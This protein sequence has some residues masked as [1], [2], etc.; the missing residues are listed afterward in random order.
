MSSLQVELV[1]A[2]R[3]VWSGEATFVI[4]RTAEG[5]LGA[6]PGHSPVLSNLKPSVVEISTTD[7]ERVKAAV[8]DGFLSIANDRVSILS[9]EAELAGEIDTEAAKAEREAAEPDSLAWL[10]ADAKV[11]ATE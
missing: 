1:A 10:I 9:E 4:A 2:E 7:G 3:I 6:L 8:S 5:E 11:R